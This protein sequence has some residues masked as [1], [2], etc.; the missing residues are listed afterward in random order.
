MNE[1]TKKIAPLPRPN[2]H[3]R[4]VAQLER[5]LPEA[6]EVGADI[7]DAIL[8]L[9]ASTRRRELEQ[10]PDITDSTEAA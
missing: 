2:Y 9:I 8:K 7:R 3:A 1:T 4:L 5:A 10:L 6:E